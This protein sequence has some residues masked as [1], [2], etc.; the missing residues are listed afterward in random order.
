MGH[1]WLIGMM[2][3]GKS[4]SGRVL[5]E[6][7]AVPFVDSDEVVA[8]HAGASVAE[9][10]SSE[11]EEG[12]RAR[13]RSVIAEIAA[14]P[15]SVVAA[16]GGAVLDPANSAVMRATGSIVLLEASTETLRSRLEHS[17]ER[18]LLLDGEALGDR[19]STLVDERSARYREVADDVVDTSDLDPVSVARR[20][21][22][23]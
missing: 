21:A 23:R 19:I 1:V 16:G 3:A 11:G 10:F 2:G 12:F 14:G 22:E 18:P 4:T 13:E 6:L 17:T 8:E 7:L 9:I 20:I 15:E 5:A